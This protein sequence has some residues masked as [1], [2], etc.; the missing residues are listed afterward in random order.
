MPREGWTGLWAL[1]AESL[2]LNTA[3]LKALF[4]FLAELHQFSGL[5]GTG[6]YFFLIIAKLPYLLLI[7]HHDH[8]QRTAE[9]T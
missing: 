5:K 2:T 3:F 8:L 1:G 4:E 9:A 6:R 7:T